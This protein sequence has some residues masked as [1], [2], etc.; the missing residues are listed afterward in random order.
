[1]RIVVAIVVLLSC[2]PSAGARILGPTAV[3]KNGG[4]VRL[5]A[6]SEE[7]VG[8]LGHRLDWIMIS[9]RNGDWQTYADGQAIVFAAPSKAQT[10]SVML[11]DTWTDDNGI[12]MARS[13]ADVV[14]GDVKPQAQPAVETQPVA[15]PGLSPPAGTGNRFQ[16]YSEGGQKYVRDN[17][18]SLPYL[19]DVGTN[20]FRIGSTRY[21]LVRQ[22]PSNVM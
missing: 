14:V 11:I 5:T 13:V 1:M 16:I 10:V 21:D 2:Q 8:L 4:L 15:Q 22:Q 17:V 3:E 9:P 12:Q 7:D 19:V 6:V 18:T 20:S